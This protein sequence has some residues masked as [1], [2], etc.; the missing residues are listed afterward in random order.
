MPIKKYIEKLNE[1]YI[2][3]GATEHT[4][5][6]ALQ[7]LLEVLLPHL[8]VLNEPVRLDC[9]APDYIILRK[10]IPVA[11]I[12]AKDIGDADLAGCG[13]NK[14]QFD[15]YKGA[16][17]NIIFTDYLDFWLCQ[18]GEITDSVRIAELKKGQIVPLLN[19]FEKF[20]HLLM[21]FSDSR[22]IKIISSEK[23]ACV[24]AGKARLMAEVI[25]YALSKNN[26]HN[27]LVGEMEAF[28]E[29]LIHDI[30]PK[31]FADLY[32]QTIAYGMF[33]ARIHDV[34]TDSFSRKKAAELIPKTNPFL[35]KL[36]QYIAGYDLDERICW[37]VDDLAEAFRATDIKAVMNGFG[38]YTQQTD[39]MVH[40]YENF[41]SAYDPKER[42]ERGVWFTPQPV[43]KFIVKA[44][45][46]ILQK[47]FGLKM[48]LADTSKISI[49]IK[50]HKQIEL[51]KVQV[52]DPAAGT[53][54]FLAET[55][56][57]I[58]EK[59][60][61]QAG[62]WQSYVE[63]H[64]IPRLN[65]FELMMAPY[66]MAHVKLDWML[67]ET[68]YKSTDKQRLRVYLT[69]SLEEH[70]PD[71][72]TLFAQFLANE[73]REANGVKRDTPVM[74]VMGNP[75]YSGESKNK[76]EWIMTK[77]KVYKN[78]PGTNTRLKERNSKWINNDYCKFIRLGQF[79]VDKNKEGILAFITSHSFLD[80]LIFRGMRWH[81][82][83]GFDKIYIIDLHGN[84]KKKET[85]PGGG[86]DENVFDIEEGTSINIFI[87][88]RTKTKKELA[89]VYHCDL[90]G[91]RQ[92]KYDY[93]IHN[94]FSNV[95]FTKLQPLAPEY[96]FVPKNLKRKSQYNKGF[97][98]V[99]L[100][101]VHSVGIVTARDEFTIHESI[102]SLRH[103]IK[104]FLSITDEE[105]RE[106]YK[107]GDDVK[108][109]SVAGARD[110]L[111]SSK[112]IFVPIAYRPFDIR[113]T[114]YSGVSKGFHCRPRYNVMRHFI[115][116]Q[117]VGLIIGRQ[118]IT[119]N[120]SHVQ[121][122][123][124][125]IDGRIHYS[126][127]GISIICP[128]YLYP[129]RNDQPV[130]KTPNLNAEIVKTISEAIDLKFEDEKSGNKNKFAPIDLLDYIYAILHSPSYRLKYKEFLKIDFPRVPYPTDTI[131]FRRLVKLGSELRNLHFMEH[132]AL[133]NHITKYPVAG[134]N[135]VKQLRWKP[136]K[137]GDT[138]RIWINAEQYFDDVPLK[139][140]EFYIGGYQP[141]QKWL[142]DR[143]GLNLNYDQIK[144]YQ[145]II[146]I[147][148]VTDEI[149]K[150]IY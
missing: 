102:E 139:A 143:K 124:E 72:G 118:A 108:D 17:G 80:S 58:H 39:P 142:K 128:L 100:F 54:T 90:Y 68:G 29:V 81:L 94:E 20:R 130:S 119:D 43:V 78:E 96:F 44:I 140:W 71:T 150:K 12:E 145:K 133:D 121:V 115:I 97:T 105:A 129:N 9:G 146:I 27:T 8:T 91:T 70:H 84:V 3:G 51:H 147:L 120:W 131:E 26:D 23:L 53:G 88:T 28:K 32:A 45:D 18:D 46:E 85:P 110:D 63:Q 35:R 11:F 19:N 30:T 89:D 113:Y 135:A 122:T 114:R 86:K 106:K 49:E 5:R 33:A 107:L 56:R 125:I 83:S 87:K 136:S 103:V 74:V 137:D 50:D 6:P 92:K 104:D 95:Q 34:S 98:V 144:H 1:K 62:M 101:P 15:R 132:P 123:K 64:L 65:G 24:M 22:P 52:L 4:H 61:D 67:S 31:E 134:N 13:K 25:E 10:D 57:Q 75:P 79:F 112:H 141:A 40:F 41:L 48:G 109:W 69:N 16:L 93:L 82:M 42:R 116:G 21:V 47:E 127:K 55:I 66:T 36:F 37:I 99:D 148:K 138:G 117:N 126:N 76:S 14:E 59:F 7:N 149:M 60:Q 73:A 2:T 77:M 38:R 111:Q